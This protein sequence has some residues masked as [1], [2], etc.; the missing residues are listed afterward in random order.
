[1]GNSQITNWKDPTI[2][3]W[4]NP[5]FRLGHFLCRYLYVYQRV[6]QPPV[7]LSVLCYH[8]SP[9]GVFQR[10]IASILGR[11]QICHTS[12][13]HPEKRVQ[14]ADWT[15]C[16]CEG[17]LFEKVMW[18]VF[19]TPCWLIMNWGFYCQTYWYKLGIINQKG[20]WIMLGSYPPVN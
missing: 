12:L 20:F 6:P 15:A 10:K 1:M 18:P 4:L 2:F 9:E 11:L 16:F 14:N 7:G 19:K 13:K 17:N 8:G 3:S 5:L